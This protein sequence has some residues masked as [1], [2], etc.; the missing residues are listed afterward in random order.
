MIP[1]TAKIW[2]VSLGA[3]GITSLTDIESLLKIALLA[4]SLVYTLF[5]LVR[6]AT[7]KSKKDDE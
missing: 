5:K 3:I 2:T 7:D 1:D 6:I 4:A